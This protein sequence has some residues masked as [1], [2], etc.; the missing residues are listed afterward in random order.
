MANSCFKKS[1]KGIIVLLFMIVTAVIIVTA[2]LGI[3]FSNINANQISQYQG[4]SNQAFLNL[5]GCLEEALGRLNRDNFYAGGTITIDNTTC[6]VSIT[7]TDP[8]RTIG[9]TAI[10]QDYTRKVQVSVNIFPTITI[11]SWQE[12]TS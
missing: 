4:I 3:A 9:I 8:T 6:T 5:D 2:T 10:N 11:S 7:G 1:K 12:L